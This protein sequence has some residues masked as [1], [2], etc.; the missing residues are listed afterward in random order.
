ML[1]IFSVDGAQLYAMKESDCWI[2][3][4]IVADL[5]PNIR[6]KKKHV[7]PGGIVPGKPKNADTFF[8]PGLH[9]V[10][11]LMREGLMIWDAVDEQV[12]R[13]N[14]FSLLETADGPA[15][16]ELDGFTGHMGAYGCRQFCSVK[17][18]RKP[19]ENHYYPAL[20]RP[21]NYDVDGCN[22]DDVDGRHLLTVDVDDYNK[23]LHSVMSSRSHADHQV[24]RRETGISMPSFFSGLPAGRICPV[25]RCFSSDQMH[26]DALNIPDLLLNLWHGNLKCDP[27]DDKSSWDWAVLT[28]DVWKKHREAVAAATRFLPNSFDRPPRNPAEKISSGYKAQEF[29]TYLYVLGPAL[30]RDILPAAYWTHFCKLVRGLRL[31]WQ[32][33]ITQAELVEAHRLLCEFVEEFEQLYYQRDV[34]RL[35]FCRQS[36][37]ALLHT[38]P[39][40]IR[41][42]P[43]GYRSQ[44][45]L[46]RTI[47]NLG[48]EIKQHSDPYANLAER[49]KRRCRVNTLK[50]MVPQLDPEPPLPQGAEELGGGYVLLRARDEFHQQIHGP[51]GDAICEFLEEQTG[52]KCNDGWVPR[53]ARWARLRLPTGQIVRSVW[54]ESKTDDIRMA[55]NVKVRNILEV[56]MGADH[57]V[58]S[59]S[60]FNGRHAICRGSIFF[61]GHNK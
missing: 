28:G 55:R 2:Y 19:G 22:H 1:L 48:E 38:C 12:H 32:R 24:R 9:H 52:E 43:G 34:T 40:I 29:V 26:R 39:E 37:H 36:I 5:N 57:F 54:K 16:A 13:S 50:V 60:V 51:Y 61:P 56:Q 49:A 10:A 47:G 45:T 15:M 14:I 41:I 27:A 4:W 44:W 7:F 21:A 18:Q 31:T 23:C 3:I 42:G 46:E 6:Y 53:V 17:G 30:L 25:P 35:N 11:A 58:L 33:D 8:Y 59:V 20:L